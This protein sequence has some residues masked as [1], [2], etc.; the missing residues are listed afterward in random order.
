MQYLKLLYIYLNIF[1]ITVQSTYID[2]LYQH[3]Y[4][5]AYFQI[6]EYNY[7]L[8]ISLLIYYIYISTFPY[9]GIKIYSQ[10][11]DV[12]IS[13]L[14]CI[15]E[16]VLRENIFIINQIERWVKIPDS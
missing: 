2:I 1:Y 16:Q 13:G 5:S 14:H 6:L 9:I 10:R 12:D 15:L 7:F 11:M 8:F 3:F 4:I